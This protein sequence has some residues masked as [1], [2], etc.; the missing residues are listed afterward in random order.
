LR[1]SC[2]LLP[3]SKEDMVVKNTLFYFQSLH[4]FNALDINAELLSHTSHLTSSG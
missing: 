1:K 4:T 3:R 2:I